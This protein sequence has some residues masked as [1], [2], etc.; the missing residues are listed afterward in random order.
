MTRIYLD[1]Q[2]KGEFHLLVRE[3]M[4]VDLLGWLNPLISGIYKNERISRCQ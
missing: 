1:R 4:L 3:M 2:Q